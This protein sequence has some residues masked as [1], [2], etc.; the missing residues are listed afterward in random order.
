MDNLLYERKVERDLRDFEAICKCCGDCCG[1]FDGDPC[2]RLAKNGNGK[3]YCTVYGERLGPQETRTGRIF[4][5]VPI[6]NLRKFG[7]LGAECGYNTKETI[8]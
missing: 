2:S 4:T 1:A 7:H 5:C 3:F 8:Q 6:R